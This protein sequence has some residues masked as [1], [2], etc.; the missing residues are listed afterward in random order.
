MPRTLVVVYVCVACVLTI[1][2]VYTVAYINSNGLLEDLIIR[3]GVCGDFSGNSGERLVYGRVLAMRSMALPQ[4]L[5]SLYWINEG[6]SFSK[7]VQTQSRVLSL[8][9]KGRFRWDRKGLLRTNYRLLTVHS[10]LLED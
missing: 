6:S 10:G 3:R 2:Q 4:S 8:E 5:T 7:V 9:Q 1:A